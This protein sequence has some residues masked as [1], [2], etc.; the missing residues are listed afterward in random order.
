LGCG[1]TL[2]KERAAGAELAWLILTEAAEPDFVRIREREIERVTRAYDFGWVRRAG[3]PTTT[4]DTIPL[5]HL[6]S[7]LKKVLAEISPDEIYVPYAH[8]AHS[9]HRVGFSA[10]AAT[11]KWFRRPGLKR[12]LAYETLSETESALGA[13][14]PFQPN[15]FVDISNF[16]DDK[17]RI[18]EYYASETAAAPFPRSPQIVRA[19]A[20]Y[21]GAACGALAA[22]AFQLLRE[23]R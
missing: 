12:I 22:E 13:H 4:L 3:F 18:L 19:Q 11:L 7:A 17:C 9:D 20:S 14:P 6:I 15:V 1:G 8:D 2:L 10:V 5:S 16:I 21:R 23:F